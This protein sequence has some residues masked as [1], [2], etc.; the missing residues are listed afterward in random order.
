MVE[1]K[2]KMSSFRLI[3]GNDVRTLAQRYGFAIGQTSTTLFRI[4]WRRVE[5]VSAAGTGPSISVGIQASERARAD[6]SV[7]L[8]PDPGVNRFGE[9]AH[10]PHGIALPSFSSP[11]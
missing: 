9:R 5:E 4:G 3:Y 6:A 8:E 1:N 11:L 7:A 10:R 2:N